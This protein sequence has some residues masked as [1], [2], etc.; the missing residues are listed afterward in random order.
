M[1]VNIINNCVISLG[2]ERFQM[3]IIS[4]FFFFCVLIFRGLD[5]A[6]HAFCLFV[7]RRTIPFVISATSF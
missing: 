3:R 1:V 7:K 4:C 2:P 5:R 6:I